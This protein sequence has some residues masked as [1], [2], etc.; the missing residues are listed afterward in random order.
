M[1][2]NF[3]KKTI[4]LFT[5]GLLTQQIT[6]AQG[7]TYISNIGQASTDYN[8]V[9]S[10]AWVAALFVT[11]TNAGGYL[12]NSVQLGMADAIGNPSGFSVMIYTR[13]TS[14]PFFMPS[15][16]LGTLDG[17]SDPETA[18]TYTY[19][20]DSNITLSPSTVYY[21]VLTS[22]TAGATG[23]YD[24]NAAGNSSFDYAT[25]GGWRV[26]PPSGG[27]GPASFQYSTNNGASWINSE[28]NLQ[29]AIDAT[30]APE[31]SPSLLLLLGSG[32]FI[33][34]RRAFRR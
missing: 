7:T 19:T 23:T 1:K 28:A 21:L 13:S 25:S 8:F 31:P 6:Q 30:P 33:Y 17:S 5:I 29:Y 18:G 9:R 34:V 3:M 14:P 4:I 16:S 26:M 10:D 27:V 11:G 32:I 20:D 24:W 12:L 15:S 2:Q 22:A